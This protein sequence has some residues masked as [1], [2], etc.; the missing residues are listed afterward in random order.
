[1][2]GLVKRQRG[3]SGAGEE[4]AAKRVREARESSSTHESDDENLTISQ[5]V[6]DFSVGD[7]SE[8]CLLF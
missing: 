5:A 1:M 4:P 7:T 6:P 3:R 8:V 2:S